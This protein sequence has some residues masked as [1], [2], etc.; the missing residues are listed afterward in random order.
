MH[1]AASLETNLL[2]SGVGGEGFTFITD[3]GGSA[4]Q[5]ATSG[6]DDAFVVVTSVG[7]QAYT[8]VKDEFANKP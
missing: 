1:P 2:P 7:G 8:V 6:A 3:I 4:Y 5:L